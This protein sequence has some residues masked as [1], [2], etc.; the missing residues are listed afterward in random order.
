M[1]LKLIARRIFTREF[2]HILA[3]SQ[4]TVDL[5][6]IPMGLHLRGVEMRPHL[7]ERLDVSDR[8]GFDAILLSYAPCGR[9][10]EGLRGT[11]MVLL[12]DR[13][14]AL[15]PMEYVSLAAGSGFQNEFA[16]CMLFPGQRQLE[17]N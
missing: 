12:T 1:H 9:G 15:P 3:R 8:L 2:E 16:N 10:T 5:E 7:Q 4:N 6:L 14:P 17:F 13:E 11:K